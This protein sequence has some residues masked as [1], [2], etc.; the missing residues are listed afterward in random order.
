MTSG[1]VLGI[2]FTGPPDI[3][4]TLSIQ[5]DQD[6]TLVDFNLSS[7]T[8]AAALVFFCINRSIP[9]PATATKQLRLNGE[10]IALVISMTQAPVRTDVAVR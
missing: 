1:Q 9:L 3:R 5:S 8:L 7:E 10:E 4:A 2:S 6:M